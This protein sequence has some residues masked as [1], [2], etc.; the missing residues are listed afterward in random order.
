MSTER[1]L[2]PGVFDAQ[3][4]ATVSQSK[5]I[6]RMGKLPAEQFDAVLAAVRA[7]LGLQA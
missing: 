1:F 5:L 3:N 7:W 2:K 6:R 4:L